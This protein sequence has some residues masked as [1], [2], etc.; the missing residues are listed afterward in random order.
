MPMK[1]KFCKYC[2][3]PF[4]PSKYSPHQDCCNHDACR[5]ARE[6]ER[7]KD[8]YRKNIQDLDWRTKLRERKKQERFR[9]LKAISCVKGSTTTQTTPVKDP[10]PI[11]PHPVSLPPDYDS[12][13]FGILGSINGSKTYEELVES[14]ENCIKFGMKFF[15]PSVEVCRIVN[16]ENP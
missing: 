8:H 2:K 9:R 15:K 7:Q 12:L 14:R 4:C 5:K 6:A 13:I 3:N 1:M 16:G 10:P 11:Q